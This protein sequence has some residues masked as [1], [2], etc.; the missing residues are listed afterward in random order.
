M[1]QHHQLRRY[2]K[3]EN[4]VTERFGGLRRV[5]LHETGVAMRQVHRKEVDLALDL[6]YRR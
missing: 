3:V 5:G 1:L 2:P 6:R 4:C